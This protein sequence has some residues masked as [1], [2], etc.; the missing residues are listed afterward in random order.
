MSG[1]TDLRGGEVAKVLLGN[2]NLLNAH[3]K[4]K[5]ALRYRQ[6]QREFKRHTPACVGSLCL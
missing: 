1:Y 6:K 2:I 4:K 3:D 5:T